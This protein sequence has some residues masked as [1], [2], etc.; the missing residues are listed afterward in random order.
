M[1]AWEDGRVKLWNADR[2]E[3]LWQQ[4]MAILTAMITKSV[5]YRSVRITVALF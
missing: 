2:I 3:F 5:R 4:S 1:R